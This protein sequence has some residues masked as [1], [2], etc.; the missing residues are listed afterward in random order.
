SS[1][2]LRNLSTHRTKRP[3]PPYPRAHSAA[4][5][6]A[7]FVGRAGNLYVL[8]SQ[9]AMTLSSYAGDTAL[10]GGR[11]DDDGKT[12]EDTARR[13]VFEEIGLPQDKDKLPLL[14]ILDPFLAGNEV[15]VTPVVV[16]ILDNTLKPVLNA[17]K[18]D[19]LFSHPLASFLSTTFP[20][21]TEPRGPFL[22]AEAHAE[23]AAVKLQ[24]HTYSD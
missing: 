6:V 8:L 19:T 21:R 12:I 4:V 16:L 3:A 22:E 2:C 20:E 14:C 11:I 9:R 10:P 23:T 13:E 24:Y 18:V 15:L 7:L 5:L 17:P 1:S